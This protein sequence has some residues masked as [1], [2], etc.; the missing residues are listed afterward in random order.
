MLLLYKKAFQ[1][2]ISWPVFYCYNFLNNKNN[3]HSVSNIEYH[4]KSASQK[5]FEHGIKF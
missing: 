1:V 2:K 3:K 4:Y 5:Y